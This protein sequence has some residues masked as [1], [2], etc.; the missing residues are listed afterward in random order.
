MQKTITRHTYIYIYTKGWSIVSWPHIPISCEVPT[1]NITQKNQ[2]CSPPCNLVGIASILLLVETQKPTRSPTQMPE[3][4]RVNLVK[5]GEDGITTLLQ[6]FLLL[7]SENLKHFIQAPRRGSKVFGDDN[8]GASWPFDTV[9]ESIRNV[10]SSRK[11]VVGENPET[12]LLQFF[13]KVTGESTTSFSCEAHKNIELLPP[14]R[15][16]RTKH[17]LNRLWRGEVDNVGKWRKDYTN[18]CAVCSSICYIVVFVK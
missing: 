12:D 13:D 18:I 17:D 9:K 14:F 10:F 16:C 6:P 8:D 2:T 7:A 4:R 3:L 5:D 1:S 15:T 11:E